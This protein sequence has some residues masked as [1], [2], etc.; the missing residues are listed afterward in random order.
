MSQK[1]EKTSSTQGKEKVGEGKET[2]SQITSSHKV[3]FTESLEVEDESSTFLSSDRR[4]SSRLFSLNRQ[5][6][7]KVEFYS[8][9]GS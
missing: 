3:S 2:E 8:G 1:V 5:G 6:L 7:I 4:R 9:D